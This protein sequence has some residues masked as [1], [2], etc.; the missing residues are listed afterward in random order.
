MNLGVLK[1]R[2]YGDSCLRARSKEVQ[3]VGPVERMLIAAMVE[4]MHA[5]KGIG[6]AAPQ[7][8][9]NERIFV[10]DTGKVAFVAINPKIIKATGR[11]MMEEGCLS[12]PNLGVNIQRAT[13]IDVQYMDENNQLIEAHLSGLPAKVF[14]HE[15]DHLDGKLIVDYLASSVKEHVLAQIKNGVY[16]GQETRVKRD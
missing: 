6:L 2:L 1:V 7:V 9:V 14:Q 11:E 8:G 15:L 10:V 16:Q 3:S 13:A 4:T 5:H 12:I